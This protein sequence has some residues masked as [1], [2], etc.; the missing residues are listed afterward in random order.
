MGEQIN[1]KVSIVTLYNRT[2][3]KVMPYKMKWQG[4]DYVM[5]KLA[6]HH[7]ARIGRLI[8]HVFHVSDGVNNYR[9]VL[10]TENL[11][12]TLEEVVYAN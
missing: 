9:L 2:T 3:G 6:Y 12:W 1:E 4:R 7:K 5:K 8:V 11:H 10:N